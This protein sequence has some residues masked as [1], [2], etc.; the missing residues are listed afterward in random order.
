MFGKK[1]FYKFRLKDH[2]LKKESILQ[3]INQNPTR[4]YFTEDFTGDYTS[5]ISKTDWEIN[6][7]DW[8]YFSLSD[9]DRNN[10]LDFLSNLYKVDKIPIPN[11]WFNQYFR[12]SG[13]D[14][15]FHNH[16]ETD[17][18]CVYFVELND[19]SLRTI[20]IDPITNKELIPKINEGDILIFPG[21]IFHRSP[22]NFTDTRKTVLS[23]NF[24]FQ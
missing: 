7:F 9:R 15:P 11:T 20:L 4:H 18:V 12:K 24:K 6:S 23:F 16:P 1:F 2:K 21:N 14:H 10:F 22:R 13:S 5:F 3:V 8:F 17:L 19:K